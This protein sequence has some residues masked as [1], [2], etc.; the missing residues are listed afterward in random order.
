[1]TALSD[2]RRF[3]PQLLL[4]GAL[5]LGALLVPNRA[6]ACG[7][8]FCQATSPVNQAAERIIFAHDA[9]KVT[10]VIEIKYQGPSTSFSLPR[11]CMV[12]KF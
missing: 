11:R 6:V 1:M 12:G 9:G 4:S 3:W 5:G 7:G 2:H 10:A 8:F